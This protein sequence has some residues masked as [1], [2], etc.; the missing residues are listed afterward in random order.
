MIESVSER[1]SGYL[2]ERNDSKNVS[3][4]VMKYAL[5]SIM[6]NTA[7]IILSLCIGL[8]DGMFKETCIALVV[9]A[10]LRLLA[11]GRHLQ[12]PILCILASSAVVV[13]VPFVPLIL[14]LI[15]ACT[16]ISLLLV[17]KFAPVD[18]KNNT[19]ITDET[20]KLMKYAALLLICSNLF[21]Q[22]QLLAISWFIVALTLIP[23][24]GGEDHE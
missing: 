21:I 14:P 5:I 3:K 8:I 11:G 9:T 22:S 13:V 19:R 7:T 16:V 17:W 15:Y 6:T 2:Y 10:V 24:K 1:I 18:F 23:Y 12:S 20:L 4:E